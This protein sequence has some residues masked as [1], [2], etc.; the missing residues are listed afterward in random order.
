M[1][2]AQQRKDLAIIVADTAVI[3]LANGIGSPKDTFV[4]S[5]TEGYGGLKKS[6]FLSA[7]FDDIKAKSSNVI[8]KGD[9][10][11]LLVAAQTVERFLTLAKDI[12]QMSTAM[13]A[14]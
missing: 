11:S 4:A 2:D 10:N 12:D 14:V 3:A 5:V 8:V 13:E 7:D 1:A 9:D 6:N